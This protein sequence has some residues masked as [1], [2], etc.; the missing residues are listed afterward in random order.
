MADDKV[1]LKTQNLGNKSIVHIV[2]RQ[3]KPLAAIGPAPRPSE[4]APTPSHMGDPHILPSQILA[5][6]YFDQLFDLL[7]LPP[8]LCTDVW[9]L[10]MK[11]PTN[12]QM[13]HR[14]K[15]I[16]VC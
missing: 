15:E 1:S 2:K 11:L 3:E 9:S 14:L 4:S 8:P 12:A 13:E 7:T 10:L 16:S 6:K 5:E